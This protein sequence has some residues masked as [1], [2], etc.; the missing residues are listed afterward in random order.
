MLLRNV[1]L[2]PNYTALELSRSYYSFS[3]ECVQK[4]Q[5]GRLE[6]SGNAGCFVGSAEGD[7]CRGGLDV[8]GGRRVWLTTSP[9]SVSRLS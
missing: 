1:G 7:V 6:F 8:I 4:D 9:P 2:S 5:N 3:T